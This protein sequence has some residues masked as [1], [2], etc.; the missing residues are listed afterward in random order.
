MKRFLTGIL[1]YLIILVQ[2]V[3]A[4]LYFWSIVSSLLLIGLL[5]AYLVS[6]KTRDFVN[7]L[8][9][10]KNATPLKRWSA[11]VFVIWV[12]IAS[13][14]GVHRES[15][16]KQNIRQ[17]QGEAQLEVRLLIQSARSS[18]AKKDI[19][20]AIRT[21]RSAIILPRASKEDKDEAWSLFQQC[22]DA[23]SEYKV[24]QVLNGMTEEQFV[25]FKKSG[26][27]PAKTFFADPNL[28]EV[29][30]ETLKRNRTKA[31]QLWD[32]ERTRLRVEEERRQA[33][34]TLL[35][36]KELVRAEA[37][38][39]RRRLKQNPDLFV[40]QEGYLAGVTYQTFM[41]SQQYIAQKDQA[42]LQRLVETGLVGP[43]KPGL[44]IYVIDT[45]TDRML[46][47]TVITAVKIRAVGTITEV[48]T[49]VEA[50][51]RD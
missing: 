8:L 37:D 24:G 1:L 47:I 21:L 12:S 33:E 5:T 16:S 9:R 31:Q 17:A 28:N 11:A 50:I 3:E 20:Q 32:A 26:A 44:E 25:A 38:E 41:K 51:K 23:I 30:L 27:L 10:V 40:T 39:R 7:L 49:N 6:S 4:E 2:L 22:K 43:L 19:D 15:A 48:W 18:I 42:A 14:A 35:R 29:F 45:K 36:E 34:Q 13:V 46:G